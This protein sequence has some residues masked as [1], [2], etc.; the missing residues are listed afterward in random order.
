MTQCLLTQPIYSHQATAT[1]STV[2]TLVTVWSDDGTSV[3]GATANISGG[4]ATGSP[5]TT[6]TGTAPTTWSHIFH[7]PLLKV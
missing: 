7:H 1:S 4:T 5:S 3:V 2:L 6:I